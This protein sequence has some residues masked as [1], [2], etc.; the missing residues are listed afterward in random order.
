MVQIKTP[1]V[2]TV[3]LKASQYSMQREDGFGL[4][5]QNIS[6]HRLAYHRPSCLFPATLFTL[7]SR[8]FLAV[9]TGLTSIITAR[10][11]YYLTLS[12]SLRV[13]VGLIGQYLPKVVEIKSLLTRLNLSSF[14]SVSLHH[15]ALRRFWITSSKN[16]FV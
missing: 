16:G 13:G 14:I 11:K 3:K 8:L 5:I 4:N 2:D 15:T 7:S 1:T 10:G 12:R 6:L 9:R